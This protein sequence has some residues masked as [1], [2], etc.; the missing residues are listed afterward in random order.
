MSTCHYL[1]LEM[2][3]RKGSRPLSH[4]KPPKVITWQSQLFA[5]DFLR[6]K[7]HDPFCPVSW[8]QLL[9]QTPL[10]LGVLC[11]AGLSLGQLPA[12]WLSHLHVPLWCSAW[13]QGLTQARQPLPLSPS[14]G[15][16]PYLETESHYSPRL[17][18]CP[19]LPGRR[20]HRCA[21]QP[22]CMFLLRACRGG[23][24]PREGCA[25]RGSR[26]RRPCRWCATLPV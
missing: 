21:P 23:R 15:L 11:R 8:S 20:D 10:A 24:P 1:L 18:P 6:K 17:V 25:A 16:L 2:L 22:S 26:W 12:T 9:S 5:S 4:A 14:Q 7:L 19:S 3:Q 13:N